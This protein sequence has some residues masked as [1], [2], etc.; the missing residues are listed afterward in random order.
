VTAII[1]F[2]LNMKWAAGHYCWH[3]ELHCPKRMHR[4][5]VQ[6]WTNCFVF[7]AAEY[8]F[9]TLY[10]VF[11]NFFCHCCLHETLST[12]VWLF[13]YENHLFYLLELSY[14]S[15]I[16]EKSGVIVFGLCLVRFFFGFLSDICTL[17]K[18]VALF[19]LPF[20]LLLSFPICFSSS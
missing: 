6:P 1:S 11:V 5:F 15:P 14:W 16:H 4:Y 20:D 12:W 3:C 8:F 7:R 9:N 18:S 2:M 17:T 19:H 13:P 10:T